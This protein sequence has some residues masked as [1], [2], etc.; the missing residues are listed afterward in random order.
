MHDLSAYIVWRLLLAALLG[1]IIGIEREWRHKP[2]GLRTNMLICFGAA[3]FT[4]LS[5]AIAGEST[6]ER[7]RIA[8]QIIPG[9]GFIGAGAVIRDRGA[10]SGITSAATIFVMASVGM[11]A[12]GGMRG[13][14]I[15]ATFVLLV[16]LVLLGIFE[17]RF[18]FHMR[19]VAFRVALPAD[20]RLES[21]QQIVQATKADARRWQTHRTD[22][23]LVVEFEAEVN[24]PQERNLL[25]KLASAHAHSE[26]R[27]LRD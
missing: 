18:G 22:D 15:F 3:L 9:I 13:T 10:V 14:A 5:I 27:I 26:I 1:G 11:A 8:S 7:A 17:D 2:A 20:G 24:T 23:A 16:A 6:G 4:I 19:L 21:V 25:A 12:G